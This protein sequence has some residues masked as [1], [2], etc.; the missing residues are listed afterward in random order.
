MSPPKIHSYAYRPPRIDFDLPVEFVVADEVLFGTSKN[1]NENGLLVDF[2]EPL[3]KGT[4]GKARFR[5]G[6][7]VLELEAR[8]AHVQ[9]FAAGLEF[10][11]T[12][13]RERSM[14]GTVM[15]VLLNEIEHHRSS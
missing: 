11:F 9:G 5:V 2:G 7:C 8:V 15:Q 3:A 12:S 14:L 4:A 13:E 1:V 10:E 6:R